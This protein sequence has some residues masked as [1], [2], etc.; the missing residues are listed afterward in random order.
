[1]RGSSM[2]DGS[3]GQVRALDPLPLPI[4]V[5]NVPQNAAVDANI[6]IRF[7]VNPDTEWGDTM[8]KL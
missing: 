4:P 3:D 8:A 7:T 1:M 6:V 5:Q 2:A